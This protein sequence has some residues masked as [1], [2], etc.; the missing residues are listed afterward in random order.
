M[1]T[2]QIQTRIED[3]TSTL[4]HAVQSGSGAQFSMLLSLIHSNQALIKP[5]TVAGVSTGEFKLP[6][7]KGGY[8]DVNELHDGV[9]TERLNTAVHEGLVGD[10]AYVN[11]Y[12]YTHS[13]TPRQQA[14]PSDEYAKVAL[15]STGQLLIDEIEES[16]QQIRVAA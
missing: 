15:M 10:F 4:S 7:A 1:R 8:P 5:E 13:N 14:L 3:Y 11:G 9:V 16:K 2:E 6:E 12:L